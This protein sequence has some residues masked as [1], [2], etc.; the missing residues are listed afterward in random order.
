M[1]EG[2]IVKWRSAHVAMG[3]QTRNGGFDVDLKISLKHIH[4]FPASKYISGHS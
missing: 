3:L 2:V 4:G 1:S